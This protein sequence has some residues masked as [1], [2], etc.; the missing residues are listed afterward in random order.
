MGLINNPGIT[1]DSMLIF[2]HGLATETIPLMTPLERSKGK[3]KP[4]P[5]PRAAP[6][7]TY[8]LLPAPKK[9]G[10]TPQVSIK[11]NMYLIVE[12]GLQVRATFFFFKVNFT[13]REKDILELIHIKLNCL[14]FCPCLSLRLLSLR[15]QGNTNA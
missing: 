12:F 5:D 11:T 1:V 13:K 3:V 4:P 15:L 8:L 9:G 7:S 14:R 6:E 2:I 10:T